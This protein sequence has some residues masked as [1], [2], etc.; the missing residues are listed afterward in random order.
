MHRYQVF[1]CT[2]TVGVAA[3]FHGPR[4]AARWLAVVLT[5]LTGR[6]HDYG[7]PEGCYPAWV[8]ER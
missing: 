8:V 4:W 7:R 2:T 3:D 6:F 5:K 1:D